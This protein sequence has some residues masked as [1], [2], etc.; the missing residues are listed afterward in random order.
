MFVLLLARC[1]LHRPGIARLVRR[2][3]VTLDPAQERLQRRLDRLRTNLEAGY[4]NASL[5][6]FRRQWREREERIQQIEQERT[7]NPSTEE[8]VDLPPL[9]QPPPIRVPRG[10]YIHGGVGTGKTMLL[11]RF[12]H[13]THLPRKAR[14]HFY[15][16]L[17]EIHDRIHALQRHDIATRGRS[18][19]V[20]PSYTPV[21]RVAHIL[22]S[23]VSLLCLDEFQVTDVADAM[24]LRQLLEELWAC[25]VVTVATSNRP[26]EHLY[27][28]GLHRELYFAPL[29]D[30]LRRQCIV[31][32]MKSE[33]DYRQH[34]ETETT[35]YESG[36]PEARQRIDEKV[37]QLRR[38]GSQKDN[39]SIPVAHG[40]TLTIPDADIDYRVARFSFDDL[41]D[42]EVGAADYRAL[43]QAFEVIVIQDIPVLTLRNQDRARRFITLMDELYEAK[44]LLIC[45]AATADPSD[46]LVASYELPSTHSESS[47]EELL[48]IDAPVAPATS[49]NASVRELAFAFRRAASRLREMTSPQWWQ[50]HMP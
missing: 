3:L 13:A 30:V 9:L 44:S 17:H 14:F 19:H 27:E 36:D 6:E 34:D 39:L 10:L 21:V 47:T 18:F 1:S 45:S 2:S 43:G 42:T 29:I 15:A 4:S 50:E 32:D 40:R 25:G 12:Y 16:F 22:A 31:H 11:D 48:G 26:P 38:D 7:N 28:G 35:Y 49:A 46:L 20:D 8:T 23:Q 37:Q 5:V 33:V 24:I 41:C